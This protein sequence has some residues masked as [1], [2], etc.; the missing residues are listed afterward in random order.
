MILSLVGLNQDL[1]SQNENPE[2]INVISVPF[3][4]Y[5][6]IKET[7]REI[8]GLDLVYNNRIETEGSDISAINKDKR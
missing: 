5:I 6:Y 7:E 2:K 3:S 8:M 4:I 1:N